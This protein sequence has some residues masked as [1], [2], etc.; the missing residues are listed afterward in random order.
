MNTE[1]LHH[2]LTELDEAL[3]QSFPGPE[4]IHVLVVGG[5]CLLFAGVTTRPTQDIDVV[6]TDL[7]GT[8]DASLVYNLTPMTRKLRTLIRSTGKRYGLKGNQ[9]MF[10][11]DDCALFLLE[12]GPLPQMRLLR[13][14]RKLHLFIPADLSYILACK[15]IGGRPEK[16]FADIAV[17]CHLLQ[18]TTRAQAHAI[19][20]HFFPN[21]LLHRAYGLSQTLDTLFGMH[22]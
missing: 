9:Q 11:N 6:I 13:T 3:V 15:L 16:D 18:V 17:L 20:T 10:L 14:Y 2:L 7:F 1:E 21:P 12:L 4:P 8:G 22:E 19:V 5:A